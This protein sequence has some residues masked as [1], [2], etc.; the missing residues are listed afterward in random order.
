MIVHPASDAEIACVFSRLAPERTAE[1]TAT[2]WHDS[3]ALLA[4]EIVKLRRMRG[5]GRPWSDL[6]TLFSLDSTVPVA[7]VGVLPFGPGWGGMIWAATPA[8]PAIAISS[9]RWWRRV[10][11]PEVLSRYRRVEFTALQ[12]DPDSHKWLAGLG[13]TSEGIAYRQG[14]RGEDFVH[15]AWVNPDHGVGIQHV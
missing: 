6:F 12:S 11:V 13:F 15:F 4:S 7:I 14:K 2:A 3:A 1:L 9:H 10:F 5:D 8:W